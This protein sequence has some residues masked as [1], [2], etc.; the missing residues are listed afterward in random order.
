MLKQ[1]FKN[2]QS[3][4]KLWNKIRKI[5][6][7][8]NVF[9]MNK[10]LFWDPK[11]KNDV[12]FSIRWRHCGAEI[13]CSWIWRHL[14]L[15]KQFCFCFTSCSLTLIQAIFA[16][17][18]CH[19]KLENTTIT[20]VLLLQQLLFHPPETHRAAVN[21]PLRHPAV[22]GSPIF[23]TQQVMQQKLSNIV[24]PMLQWHLLLSKRSSDCS[25][26]ISTQVMII[27]RVLS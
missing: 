16:H 4:P 19:L 2:G 7:K 20:A 5:V 10:K 13:Y 21:C 15:Q 3:G 22:Q 17:C 1:E 25:C 9:K 26:Y 8:T 11:A 24:L 6:I 14:K 18:F 12:Y 27:T 23:F